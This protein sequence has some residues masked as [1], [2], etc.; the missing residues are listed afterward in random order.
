MRFRATKASRLDGLIRALGG[1]AAMARMFGRHPSTVS[2]WRTGERPLPAE[3]AL[4]MRRLAENISQEMIRL[5]CE[6]QADVRQGEDR[7]ARGRA[8]RMRAFN[9][10]ARARRLRRARLSG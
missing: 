2:R 4:R 9:E 5:A 6:M 3:V 1:T 8:A 7:T 10:A